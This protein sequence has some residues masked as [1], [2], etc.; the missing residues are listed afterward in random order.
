[1][2]AVQTGAIAEAVEAVTRATPGVV[3]LYSARSVVSHLLDVGTRAI[4]LRDEASLVA[5]QQD[6]DGLRVTLSIGVTFGSSAATTASAVHG[7][8]SKTLTER[9]LPDADVHLTVAHIAEHPAV[10]Q[11]SSKK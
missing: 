4:G 11:V 6:D 9:G 10:T 3:C 2:S 8:I 5:V 7:N 1:M